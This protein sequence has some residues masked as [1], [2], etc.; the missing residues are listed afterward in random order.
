[1]RA[2]AAQGATLL[3]EHRAG[4]CAVTEHNIRPIYGFGPFL[5]DSARRILTHD[6]NEIRLPDR[7]SHLLLLLIQ[8]NGTVGG[9]E[10]I[11]ARVWPEG[12][13]RNSNISQHVYMLRRLLDEYARDRAYVITV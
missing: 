11:V 4:G 12:P 6:L 3:N 2:A 8:A 7:V 5:F 10:T 13:P 9:R 1:M